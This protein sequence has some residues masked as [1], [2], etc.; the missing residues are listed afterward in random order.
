MISDKEY[1]ERSAV[2]ARETRRIADLMDQRAKALKKGV[3]S[4]GKLD[5]K[6][7]ND[8]NSAASQLAELEKE[9]WE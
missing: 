7:S 3:T 8:L 6:L 1:L 9:R 5:D 2:L 4:V